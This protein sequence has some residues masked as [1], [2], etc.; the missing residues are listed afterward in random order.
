MA[1]KTAKTESCVHICEAFQQSQDLGE[2][3]TMKAD[4]EVGV[5]ARLAALFAQCW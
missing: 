4:A 2:L 3:E 1:G 5:S